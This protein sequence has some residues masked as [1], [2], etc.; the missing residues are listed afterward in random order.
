MLRSATPFFPDIF[1]A[2]IFY[3]MLRRHW[4]LLFVTPPL[5]LP[6]VAYAPLLSPTA[7]YTPIAACLSA[8]IIFRVSMFSITPAYTLALTLMLVCFRLL[9]ERHCLF[10]LLISAMLIHF[11]FPDIFIICCSLIFTYAAIFF[12]LDFSASLLVSHA[13]LIILPI[14]L[15]ADYWCHWY[16]TPF[17]ARRL[18]YVSVSL[19][20]ATPVYFFADIAASC[21]LRRHFSLLPS[22]L[23][24]FDFAIFA[25]CYTLFAFRYFV[26]CSCSLCLYFS[27][28]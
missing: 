18:W 11:L 13:C 14:A 12:L 3:A 24:F 5:R 10:C 8:A 21:P 22:P 9:I 1:A 25:W 16:A 2:A 27:F 19:R 28:D 7:F 26:W 15:F 4:S 23:L 6:L 17:H 20:H